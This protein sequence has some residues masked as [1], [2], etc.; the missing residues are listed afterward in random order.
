MSESKKS[1][2]TLHHASSRSEG[3]LSQHSFARSMAEKEDSFRSTG[4]T[5]SFS[6]LARLDGESADA[7]R[8]YDALRAN[9]IDPDVVGGLGGSAA[10][11]SSDRPTPRRGAADARFEAQREKEQATLRARLAVQEA[12]LVNRDSSGYVEF[13]NG[14]L[15][16][17]GRIRKSIKK[18][19]FVLAQL[20]SGRLVLQY[21][22]LDQSAVGG[23][24]PKGTICL[25]ECPEGYVVQVPRQPKK[26]KWSEEDS[27]T[28]DESSRS[29]RHAGSGLSAGSTS[30]TSISLKSF[31]T[32]FN[33]SSKS[34]PRQHPTMHHPHTFFLRRRDNTGRV[35]EIRA[36]ND[37]EMQRWVDMIRQVQ[38]SF[39]A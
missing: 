22:K 13:Y 32:S 16:K 4:P 37:E 24:K 3:G 1:R 21:F 15:E 12:N 8:D 33:S 17:K 27:V 36:E 20:P 38:A 23:G 2:T 9:G 39:S 19:F 35:F 11:S 31:S 25:D 30:F 18:R 10:A 29:P 14:W 7:L 5:F 34:K 28:S 26:P 6:D